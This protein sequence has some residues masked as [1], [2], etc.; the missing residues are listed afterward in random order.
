MVAK[1]EMAAKDS[2]PNS[3]GKFSKLKLMIYLKCLVIDIFILV[4]SEL[5]YGLLNAYF[6]LSKVSSLPLIF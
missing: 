6:L 1:L 5:I 3:G 2:L 4:L